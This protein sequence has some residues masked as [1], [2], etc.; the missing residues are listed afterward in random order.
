MTRWTYTKG[1]HDLGNGVYAYLQPDGSWGLSNAGLIVQGEKCVLVD[2]LFDLA[3]TREMLDE[4]KAASRSA[5]EI[6]TLVITHANGDHCFGNQL[7]KEA[8]IIASKSCAEEMTVMPPKMLAQLMKSAP[9][10]GE[11]GRYLMEG[12]GKFRFDNIDLTM[13]TKTF[14][15]EM[16][17]DV[18]G[19][20]VRLIE[21]GPAHTGGD[22]LVCIPDDKVL[23]A[24]DILFING[25]PIMWAGPAANWIKACDLILEMDV[26]AIVPGHGPVTDKRGVEGIKR[27]IEYVSKEARKRFDE[28]MSAA[29]TEGDIQLGDYASWSDPERIVINVDTLYREFSG[30]TPPPNVIELFG[31]MAELKRRRN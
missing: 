11:V 28:G 2:T 22:V 30:D 8:E 7:V 5:A 15:G 14:E 25:T 10:M 3:L 19:K 31:R 20:E 13:P 24:G 17:I 4:M 23:F 16:R 27:Y 26:E 18:A 12:F 21:V 29:E 1:L 9:E 6:D